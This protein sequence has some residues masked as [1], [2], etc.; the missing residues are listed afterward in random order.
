VVSLFG[1]V[2]A[3]A[4][5]AQAARWGEA[6]RLLQAILE[7]G[8]LVGQDA[9]GRVVIELAVGPRDFER[10]MAFGAE[11]A[12]SEDGGDDEPDECVPMSACWFW[13][14]GARFFGAADGDLEPPMRVGRTMRAARA[15]A[16]ALLLAVLP[17]GNDA[18][19]GEAVS[20]RGS[21]DVNRAAGAGAGAVLPGLPQGPSVRRRMHQ[22]REAVQEGSG[23]RVLGGKRAMTDAGLV[24]A[25]IA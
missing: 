2:P 19:A 9:A 5:R 3:A 7:G 14:G 8:D 12:E 4:G 1:R 11:A 23:L 20:N 6:D 24:L 15:V 18:P 10:L 21:T 22:R 16:L 25:K 17:Y 13:E